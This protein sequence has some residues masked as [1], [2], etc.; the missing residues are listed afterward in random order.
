MAMS[1]MID[2]SLLSQVV[3][4][5]VGLSLIQAIS[6]QMSNKYIEEIH[7]NNQRANLVFNHYFKSKFHE[8]PSIK[9]VNLTEHYYLPDF[10]NN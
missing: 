10:L 5:F 4:V 7:L 3:P 6:T 8:F 1:Q 9:E 2:V